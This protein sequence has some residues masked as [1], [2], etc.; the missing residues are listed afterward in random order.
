MSKSVAA[1][2]CARWGSLG[3][4]QV[5]LGSFFFASLNRSIDSKGLPT[6]RENTSLDSFGVLLGAF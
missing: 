3:C 6:L 1:A 5:R 4:S 2:I